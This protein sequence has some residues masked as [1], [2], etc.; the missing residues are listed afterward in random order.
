MYAK[1][2]SLM[3]KEII[4]T[5]IAHFVSLNFA[6]VNNATAMIGVKLKRENAFETIL[7][8]TALSIMPTINQKLLLL[9][10]FIKQRYTESINSAKKIAII[11]Q[12]MYLS[13]FG[14]FHFF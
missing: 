6:P 7:K 1:I 12:D 3:N 2:A 5:K 10:V 4:G 8:A 13:K 9:F 14:Y 11:S